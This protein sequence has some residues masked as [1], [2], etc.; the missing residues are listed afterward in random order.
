[1]TSFAILWLSQL[2][3]DEDI[4]I[5][6]NLPTVFYRT[7][8]KQT[9]LAIKWSLEIISNRYPTKYFEDSNK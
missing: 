8:R 4:Y 1:M 2:T 7:F 9:K 6:Y 3:L 5:V